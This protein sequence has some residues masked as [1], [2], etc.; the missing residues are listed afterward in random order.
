MQELQS[1]LYN[2][3]QIRND[4]HLMAQKTEAMYAQIKELDI[5]ILGVIANMQKLQ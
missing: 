3:C 1:L 5:L 4:M 2:L